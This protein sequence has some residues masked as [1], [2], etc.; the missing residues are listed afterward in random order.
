V[1]VATIEIAQRATVRLVHS[2]RLKPSV[3][4]PLAPTA[5][6]LTALTE[7]EG[8]TSGRLEAETRGLGGLDPRELA[9]NVPHANFINAAFAYPRTTGNRFNGPERGAW[10]CGFDVATAI[11]EVGFHLTRELDYIGR[12][13]NTSDYAEML[14]DFIGLYHDLRGAASPPP[15]LHPDPAIGYPAGQELAAALMAEGSPGLIYPS[16]RHRDGTCLVA[17]RPAVVQNVRQ[18]AMWRLTWAGS[19]AYAA[20]QSRL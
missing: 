10:Y 6:L 1:I 18:G 14:A 7:L 9:F 16:V 20:S 4:E 5:G 11:A 12:Y 8:A 3:L 2:G 13:D 19:R 15:C 17:F